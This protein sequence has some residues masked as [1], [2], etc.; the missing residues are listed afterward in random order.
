[1]YVH[2]CLGVWLEPVVSRSYYSLRRP[3]FTKSGVVYIFISII[4]AVI[5]I[6]VSLKAELGKIADKGYVKSSSK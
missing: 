6:S 5:L 2:A 1:M 3:H 4:L